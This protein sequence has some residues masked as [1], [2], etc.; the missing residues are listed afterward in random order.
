MREALQIIGSKNLGGAEGWFLRFS[1][2]L[3]E[4][5]VDTHAIVR[6]DSALDDEELLP[7]PYTALP[8][9]TVWD[10]LSR[11]EVTKV[12]RQREPSIVQTYMGRATRLTHIPRGRGPV[13][14][15]RLG[16]FYK[17]D[18]YRHAHAWIGNTRGIRDY[19]VENGFPADRVFHIYNFVDEPEP[20]PAAE[21]AGLR[22]A[23]AIGPDDWVLMSPGRFVPFKGH[24]YVLEALARL[25]A[26]IAGRRL[27]QVMLGDGPLREALHDQAR[28]SGIEDRIVW[29]GWQTDSRPWYQLADLVVFPS[30]EKE[31]FGNV[32]PET[33]SHGKPLVTTDFRG[34]LEYTR[35]GEDV[36]R[37][38]CANG[39]ALAEAI[40]TVLEDEALAADLARNGL[41]RAREDFG[42]GPVMK[43]YLDLYESLIR[44]ER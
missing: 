6:R 42:R 4:R 20:V 23:W 1:A 34:A 18:G 19:L 44:R 31:P 32:V 38:P 30:L 9:R 5:G 27:R 43:Q 11:Y 3:A 12:I 37:A 28:Q 16:G 36:L 39:E 21:L 41:R 40:R 10:P 24:R 17:L 2:A 29:A 13:H 25:P 8:L 33:W 14:V 22:E 26:E 7:V 15:S 35:N